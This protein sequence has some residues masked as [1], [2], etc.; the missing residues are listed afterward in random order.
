MKPRGTI[1]FSARHGTYSRLGMILASDAV[2]DYSI[3]DIRIQQI[4]FSD[5][6]TVK[7]T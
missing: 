5:H 4:I 1:H 2:C 7:M 6:A 3:L